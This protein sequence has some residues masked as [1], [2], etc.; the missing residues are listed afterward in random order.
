MRLEYQHLK[1]IK[2]ICLISDEVLILDQVDSHPQACKEDHGSAA[3]KTSPAP[4]ANPTSM[5]QAQVSL[6]VFDF[7]GTLIS[8]QSGFL[9]SRYLY[10]RG[11]LN[12]RQAA[13]L[14]WWGVRY[15]LHLP[16]RQEE[17]R[18]IIFA[19]LTSHT[20][21]EVDA[22]MNDFYEQIIVPRYR[23]GALAEV[24]RRK[25][26]GCVTLLVSATFEQI[27]RRAAHDLQFDGYLATSMSIGQDG[28]YTGKVEGPV[29]EGEQKTQ[30]VAQWANKHLG[31][32]K[33]VVEYAY[34]DHYSDKD[35]L[36]RAFEAF[37]V[38]P[39]HMLKKTAKRSD[40]QILHWK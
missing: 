23:P 1:I 31:P 34:G 22:L 8:G 17:S 2:Q 12:L 14:S 30:A 29:I 6:A 16:Q 20:P 13:R 18:E 25:K 3:V 40:W 19:S 28:T 37:A 32:H 27:A 9:F 38:S 11:Y 35:L 15:V 5:P 39:G 4:A 10:S 36:G 21:A 33:W 26:E 24:A 7:D